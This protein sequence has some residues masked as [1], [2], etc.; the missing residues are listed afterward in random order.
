MAVKEDT[1]PVNPKDKVITASNEADINHS[2][3]QTRSTT[4]LISDEVFH[5]LSKE[6]LPPKSAAREQVEESNRLNNGVASVL[7]GEVSGKDEKEVM[8]VGGRTTEEI[9][10][11]P[12][13]ESVKQKVIEQ[14]LVERG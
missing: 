3:L 13:M 1:T 12:K 9:P 7:N 4:S 11:V 6:D 8:N 2:P 10:R 5:N 14:P